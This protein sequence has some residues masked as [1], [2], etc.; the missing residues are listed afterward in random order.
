VG[1]IEPIVGKGVVEVKAGH[2]KE[3]KGLLPELKAEA[4]L[5]LSEGR[6]QKLTQDGLVV[7]TEQ[8]SSAARPSVT[9]R[10]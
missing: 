5:A 9:V 8:W 1:F 7:M 6:K 3:F 4:F 2:A 10:L